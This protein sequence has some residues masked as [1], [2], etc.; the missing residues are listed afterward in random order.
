MSINILDDEVL[1]RNQQLISSIEDDKTSI[2]TEEE[3]KKTQFAVLYDGDPRKALEDAR[4]NVEIDIS[5]ANNRTPTQNIENDPRTN[6]INFEG[7]EKDGEKWNQLSS[8]NPGVTKSNISIDLENRD[9]L[10]NTYS[11]EDVSNSNISLEGFEK[12]ADGKWKKLASPTNPGIEKTTENLEN[13]DSLNNTYSA[14][15]TEENNEISILKLRDSEGNLIDPEDAKEEEEYT[16][17]LIAR[18]DKEQITFNVDN[19][20]SRF[21][22]LRDSEGN[23]IDPED[24]KEEEE[25]TLVLIARRDKE[26]VEFSEE[27]NRVTYNKVYQNSFWSNNN[28]LGSRAKLPENPISEVSVNASDLEIRNVRPFDNEA[29]TFLFGDEVRLQELAIFAFMLLPYIGTDLALSGIEAFNNP[30]PVGLALSTPNFINAVNNLRYFTGGEI[31]SYLLHNFYTISLLKRHSIKFPQ[32]RVFDTTRE[33]DGRPDIRFGGDIDATGFLKRARDRLL[34]VRDTV[35]SFIFGQTES[36]DIDDGSAALTEFKDDLSPEIRINTI[37]PFTILIK[38]P[39]NLIE[40]NQEFQRGSEVTNVIDIRRREAG[41]ANDVEIQEEREGAQVRFAIRNRDKETNNI[42]DLQVGSILVAPVVDDDFRDKLPRFYIP[43]QFNPNISEA[44]AEAQYESTNVLSRIGEIFSF[45]NVS[46][47][48][49][50]LE[51][52]YIATSN[53]EDNEVAT[54]G[55]NWMNFYTLEKLQAIEKAYRSLV[56]PHYPDTNIEQGYIYVK[57]PLLRVV[58]GGSNDDFGDSGPYANILTY[59]RNSMTTNIAES[60]GTLFASNTR[61]KNFI[62]T[63]VTIKKDLNENPIVLDNKGRILDAMRFSVSLNLT[64]VSANYLDSLPDFKRYSDEYIIR[65]STVGV[66]GDLEV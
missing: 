60:S 64:E 57:P 55:N 23:L 33:W 53:R 49:I 27:N 6:E 3:N 18:R 28:W 48:T 9:N 50:T 1:K 56:L 8:S 2:E 34:N 13:R 59:G 4:R 42:N 41:F 21:L 37:N 29:Q 15:F 12:G 35:G 40:G 26:S 65:M 63:N 16:P 5:S 17:V 62:A 31:T 36:S 54:D 7:F 25:Y 22:K 24:A 32:N 20:D 11:V 51:T 19:F 45:T 43:F 61:L 10:N 44:G 46:S 52:E 47:L 39:E 38:K 14:N 66:S 30:N 58:M